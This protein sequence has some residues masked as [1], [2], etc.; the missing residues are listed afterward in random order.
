MK[1]ELLITGVILFLFGLTLLLAFAIVPDYVVTL[2][3]MSG[4]LGL[5]IT[6]IGFILLYK[7]IF[8]PSLHQYKVVKSGSG[9]VGES[10]DLESLEEWGSEDIFFS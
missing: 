6:L 2:Y 5:G 8:S 4:Y 3:P 10:A 7:G 9:T 1:I